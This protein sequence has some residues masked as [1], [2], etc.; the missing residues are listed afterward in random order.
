MSDETISVL[1]RILDP[2]MKFTVNSIKQMPS[3]EEVNTKDNTLPNLH[4]DTLGRGAV[5]VKKEDKDTN[6]TDPSVTK[7]IEENVSGLYLFFSSH[8]YVIL[9][10]IIIILLIILCV[11]IYKYYNTKKKNKEIK[12]KESERQNVNSNVK[13]KIDN[14]ISSYIIDEDNGVMESDTYLE[15]EPTDNHIEEEKKPNESED[16]VIDNNIST[17]IRNAEYG[18]II[19][20]TI[21]I[22]P[23][24]RIDPQLNSSRFEE[25][26]NLETN[27]L[28]DILEDNASNVGNENQSEDNA[29]NVGNENQSEDNES[30]NDDTSDISENKSETNESVDLN[31]IINELNNQNI[32]K[33]SSKLK[34]NTS[35]K[36]KSDDQDID[37]FKAF[38]NKN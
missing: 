35:K 19:Q 10:I 17:P 4:Y 38:I 23:K 6:N 36:K 9:T 11:L 13:E 32:K 33:K 14:Y 31:D 22:D 12:E 7:P 18:I 16:T 30:I 29:S 37:H 1:P 24:I 3:K 26:D 20:E 34:N 21:A 15:T 2:S 28:S 5:N 27:S 8:K 25:I